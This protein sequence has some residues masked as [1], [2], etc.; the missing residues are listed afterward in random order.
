[1][2]TARD[3]FSRPW[4]AG[5][6]A[7]SV[8]RQHAAQKHGPPEDMTSDTQGNK[9]DRCRKTLLSPTTRR[10]G[11]ENDQNTFVVSFAARQITSVSTVD[12]VMR[13]G[14]KRISPTLWRINCQC[15]LRKFFE[16]SG[17]C[18]FYVALQSGVQITFRRSSCDA[19]VRRIPQ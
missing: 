18:N 4:R 10:G 19:T 7:G 8:V 9:C 11:G 3:W 16:L 1:M 17:N 5:P 6:G 12:V 13:P 14:E 2:A 15:L